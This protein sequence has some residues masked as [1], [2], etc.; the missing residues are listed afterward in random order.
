MKNYDYKK[1][2]QKWQKRWE[3]SGIYKISE[4]SFVG[5]GYVRPKYYLLDMFPY[6][7]GDGLHMGHT[8]SYTSTDV[9]YRYKKM[10]GFNVLH[11]QG[12][13]SFGL[14]AENYAIKTGVHP[15]E[16][17]RKNM[18]TYIRQMKSLGFG[19]DFENKVVTSSPEYYHWTQWIFTKFF[20][21]GLV[22]KKTDRI[23]WCDSCKT[24]LANEQ[25]ED[26]RCER[27]KSEVIQKN[28][29]GWFFKITDFSE[30]LINDLK[31]LD[32]PEHTKKNQINWIGK[33]D[34]AEIKFKIL[35]LRL[36]SE[37][38][39]IEVFT[40]RPDTLFGVTYCVLAPEHKIIEELKDSIENWKEVNEYLEKTKRKSEMERIE[41]KEKTGIELKGIKA[42]NPA[43]KEE[44]PLFI[45][46][47][48]LAH[49]GTGAIMAVPAHDE[50]D[51]EFAEK[52]T[53][54][55]IC[56]I[57][58]HSY[59]GTLPGDSL[60]DATEKTKKN[61]EKIQ[62]GE[63][64]YVYDGVLINSGKFDGMSSDEAKKAITE[65]VGGKITKKYRLRDWSISR[66]RYWGA[67]IPIVYSPSGEAYTV[68]KEHL[69][70][71]L[72]EDV[73]FIPTGTSPL[74]KSKELKE[75]TEKIFGKGWTSEVDT[76]DTFVCSS[77]YYLRYPDPKNEKE[78]C[79]KEK[80]KQWLPVDLYIGGAEHTY[81]HLLYARF[82][83]KAMKKIGLLDFSEPFLKLRHQGMVLDKDGVKM[84][85]SKGNVV[86][87]DD[88]V[89]RFGADA[90][91]LYIM[92]AGP[93]EDDVIWNENGVV[94]LSRFL[95]K[96]WK[97]QFLLSIDIKEPNDL[98]IEKITH[99]TIKKVGE[100]LEN[101][102][103]NTA[104]SQMM[105]L[106]NV[107]EKESGLNI[108]NYKLLILMLAPLA[109]HIT[110]ELW[111]ILGNNQSIHLSEWPK[112]DESLAKDDK[113]NFVIQI[114]GKVRDVIE[115][116]VDINENKARGLAEKS[117]NIKKLIEGKEIKK[118][119][120]VRGRLLNI[121]I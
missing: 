53:L 6:P 86:N 69:P 110:E 95:E 8:E 75:R 58:P 117:E 96:V 112:Y 105:I 83:T 24:G 19:Y 62:K 40:T 14:P 26:G 55:K 16:T 103:F 82:I 72:P 50:R 113:I 114:N 67:P 10:K 89:G 59:M 56:V 48:V 32:W 80:L 74:I 109:P 33:S 2:E 85:K 51:F 120:F 9:L 111:D 46:D 63:V 23:N 29:P 17:T 98:K 119:I 41:G 39:K 93:L 38:S 100:D 20:E 57:N 94:G 76:M 35:S 99:K 77:W 108:K 54:S 15:K 91:R 66:Q 64:V 47:Y 1:I 106:V 78:F 43:N 52:F 13:D 37:I 44:V 27:C 25:V 49:Y 79:S 70:W 21:A 116:D 90:V 7:S 88:V 102:K 30:E 87:P 31:D 36:K 3:D 121:I 71:L 11:L 107:M 61:L 68:P 115:V 45:A 81:M 4:N 5:L 101:L 22:Y 73:D 92:F 65:F 34:G 42:I 104:I 97:L 28:I 18:E 84:S 118:A 12:F 60:L